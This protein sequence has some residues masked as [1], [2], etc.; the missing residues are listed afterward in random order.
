MQREQGDSVTGWPDKDRIYLHKTGS[1]PNIK[2]PTLGEIRT[3]NNDTNV[4][5]YIA[6][7]GVAYNFYD[8][9]LGFGGV[10][11]NKEGY[12]KYANAKGI[13]IE[14]AA[15]AESNGLNQQELTP[16]Q[17]K[18]GKRLM[19]VL[20]LKGGK[21]YIPNERVISHAQYNRESGTSNHIDDIS[22]ASRTAMNLG[23]A[24]DAAEY[25]KTTKVKGKKSAEG[26]VKE[27]KVSDKSTSTA[28]KSLKSGDNEV[29]QK[30][31]NSSYH[32]NLMNDFPIAPEVPSSHRRLTR[33]ETEAWK[34]KQEGEAI[35]A[36]KNNTGRLTKEQSID[37]KKQKLN[38]TTAEVKE[39][40][41]ADSPVETTPNATRTNNIT[42]E[43]HRPDGKFPYKST[44]G[45]N[46]TTANNT[47]NDLKSGDAP[48]TTN[49]GNASMYID[50]IA[51]LGLL[52]YDATKPVSKFPGAPSVAA[53]A[54]R[55]YNP[56]AQ[57]GRISEDIAKA[58]ADIDKNTS[59]SQV[60]RAVKAQLLTGGLRAKSEAY[61][62][63]LDRNVTNYNQYQ[64]SLT[65]INKTN[66]LLQYDRNKSEYAEQTRRRDATLSGVSGVMAN[67]GDDITTQKNYDLQ[68]ELANTEARMIGAT[69]PD[70]A[71]RIEAEKF[72]GN[73]PG[74]IEWAM[75]TQRKT[76][77]Q[78]EAAAAKYGI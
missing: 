58:M 21:N 59:N 31:S 77:K 29:F 45:T 28:N 57:Q 30:N 53:P 27:A 22:D 51:N 54:F 52:A 4:P 61:S 55:Q 37:V 33:E 71:L 34:R 50:N 66:S 70:N 62:K 11:S 49:S 42:R 3:L 74:F 41:T 47:T 78:A 17:I 76:K 7:N 15:S 40:A 38:A 46:A 64:T 39:P 2:D 69:D 20:Q 60:A 68:R 18:Q 35:A 75:T 48:S 14:F 24:S 72:R 19:T 32:T 10:R 1:D 73:K 67:L 65:D 13:G 16:A 9:A 5:Y 12:D 6:R 36:T 43:A 23:P 8:H 44:S 25:L 56:Y 26:V 63:A